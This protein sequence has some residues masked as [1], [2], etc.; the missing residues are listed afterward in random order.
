[1]GVQTTE[2]KKNQLEAAYRG[3]GFN[4]TEFAAEVG[5]DQSTV[6]R[7]EFRDRPVSRLAR[8]AIGRVLRVGP[9]VV[10][11]LFTHK[12]DLSERAA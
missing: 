11:G 8:Q 7:W 10:D 2:G 3:A 12:S 4:R 5:V 1:M 6:W 9:E